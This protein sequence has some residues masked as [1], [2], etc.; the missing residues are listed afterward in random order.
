MKVLIVFAH[1]EPKSFSAALKDIAVKKLESLGHEVNVSDLYKMAWSPALSEKDFG[2]DR[3]NPEYL[4]LSAE[5]ENAHAK[6]SICDAVRLEQA[7]LSE[8]DLVLFH[9]PVWWFSMPAILK[10]WVDRVFSRG[11]AYST[12]K[13]YETGHFKGKKA[14]LCIT[15]GTASTLYEPNGIDGD[16]MHVL[17]PIHNGMLGYTGFTVYPPYAAWMP[18]RVSEEDRAQYLEGY[19]NRLQDVLNENVEPLFF[20][21]WS[22][23]DQ[24]Q[25]LKPEVKAKSGV[26]WNPAVGQSFEEAAQESSMKV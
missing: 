22:D 6:G 9:F 14:M 4:D 25:R 16:L 7:K 5:Q 23:Y 12:G 11:Y 2:E 13:K 10:G 24:T 19:G 18:A 15:T 1:P 26:Q 20:H 21:P 8:A 17:W 3:A